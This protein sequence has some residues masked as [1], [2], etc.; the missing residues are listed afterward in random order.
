MSYD[1]YDYYDYSAGAD[2]T[3]VML[4]FFVGM[5]VVCLIALVFSLV[6]YIFECVGVYTIAKRRGIKNPWLAW[7][8]L[9][10]VWIWG[11]IA[12]HYQYVAKGQVKNRRMILLILS[13]VSY[14]LVLM[15]NGQVMS[16]L[17]AVIANADAMEYMSEAEAMAMMA[18]LFGG[19]VLSMVASIVAIVLMVFQYIALYEIFNS[20]DPSNSTMF[21]VLSILFSVATPFF[22]FASRNKDLG[23]PARQ[24]EPQPQ[25]QPPYQPSNYTPK[26]SWEQ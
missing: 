6:C 18:P 4:G 5:L 1:Y 3:E 9:G 24:P 23:M 19:T 10:N 17:T 15:T 2:A 21:L 8:P 7:I 16:A 20:C 11:C 26:E 22:L 14:V 12:D 25:Y 13:L